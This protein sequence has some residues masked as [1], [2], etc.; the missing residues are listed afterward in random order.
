MATVDLDALAAEL[1]A[2]GWGVDETIGGGIIFRKP[3]DDEDIDDIHVTNDGTM[4]WHDKV[5]W[6]ALD[7]IRR[8]VSP[9]PSRRAAVDVDAVLN[10]VREYAIACKAIADGSDYAVGEARNYL[11]AIRAMLEPH[12]AAR[13]RTNI[14]SAVSDA[15]VSH[16][17]TNKDYL[18]VVEVTNAVIRAIGGAR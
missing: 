7:I 10:L 3:T 17:A 14:L 15:L 12:D 2:A 1:R 9:E 13:L 4:Y 16:A 6:S 8:H 11:A 5:D 18:P